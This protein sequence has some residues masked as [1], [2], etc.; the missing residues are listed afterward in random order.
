MSNGNAD[1][2]CE[3]KQ[4][5]IR[6]MERFEYQPS[7]FRFIAC[8][9]SFIATQSQNRSWYYWSRHLDERQRN[10]RLF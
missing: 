6:E 2:N 3:E 9:S 4:V 1:P 10:Y 8:K 5:T 7:H